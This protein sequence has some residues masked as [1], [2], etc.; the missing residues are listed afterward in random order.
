MPALAHGLFPVARPPQL[1]AKADAQPPALPPA[2]QCTALLHSFSPPPRNDPQTTPFYQ[3]CIA[4]ISFI[5][6]QVMSICVVGLDYGTWWYRITPQGTQLSTNKGATWTVV[7]M[8]WTLPTQNWLNNQ[9]SYFQTGYLNWMEA[10]EV[11]WWKQPVPGSNATTWMWFDT[12]SQLPFRLMF[13]APPSSPAM[14]DPGQLAFFQNFSFTYFPSF[15]PASSPNVDTWVDPVIAGFQP[16]NPNNQKLVV[17]NSCFF[18]TTYMTPVDSKS[19]PLPTVVLYQWKP[20]EGYRV[21]SDRGQ[22]TIMSYEY[23]PSAGF[24][25]QVAMLYGVAPSGTT[26]PPL[27]GSGYI[28]N[29]TFFLSRGYPFPIVWSC[30]NIGLGQEPPDWARIPAVDGTIHASIH[31]NPALSPGQTTNIISVLFPPTKEYPQG[32]Y[33]WT[34]Y[35]PFP[36]SDGTRSRPVTFME[37]ASTIAE[38]GTSLALADYYDYQESPVWFPPEFFDLPALCLAK[39][40]PG[41]LKASPPKGAAIRGTGSK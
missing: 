35:S 32:R 17:W 28:Y 10:Q 12:A 2:W 6:N 11:D 31:N 26:P 16:G 22:A 34:W 18:M 8:G 20:N 36:G 7:D 37:S 3:M 9:P 5:A 24:Q 21:A 27:A 41:A 38:G 1:R 29:E 39:P 23:N 30:D 33:L 40:K 25:D 13:G 15:A 4:H 19:M 14:G